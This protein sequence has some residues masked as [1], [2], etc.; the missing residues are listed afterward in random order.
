MNPPQVY[1]CS[2]GTYIPLWWSYAPLKLLLGEQWED[3]C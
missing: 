1:I 2:P 3:G